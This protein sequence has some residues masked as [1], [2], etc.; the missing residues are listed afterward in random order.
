MIIRTASFIELL[1]IHSKIP[2]MHTISDLKYFSDRIGSKKYISLVAEISGGLIGYKL[3]YWINSEK[4]YSWLGGV[5][6]SQRKNG[7]AKALLKRQE[8]E[9]HSAGGTEISVKSMNKYPGMLMMLIANGYQVT[10]YKKSGQNDG[11]IEFSKCLT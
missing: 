8:F 9:V 2:E 1:E 4:F 5:I 6:P 10:A 3:G 7:I 11:K